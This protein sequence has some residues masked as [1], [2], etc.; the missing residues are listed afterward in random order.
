M[1]RP[2]QCI[3]LGQALPVVV[4]KAYAVHTTRQGAIHKAAYTN[5]YAKKIAYSH[6]YSKARW[7]QLPGW[8]VSGHVKENQETSFTK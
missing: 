7:S 2:A 8:V 5:G 3:R 6:L 1:N 4:A